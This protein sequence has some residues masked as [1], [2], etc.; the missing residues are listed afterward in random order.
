[1]TQLYFHTT[2]CQRFFQRYHVQLAVC[3]LHLSHFQNHELLS[4]SEIE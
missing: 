3:E 4:S 1:M 2:S